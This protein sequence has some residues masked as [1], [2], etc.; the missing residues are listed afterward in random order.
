[1]FEAVEKNTPSISL[2]FQQSLELIGSAPQ[3]QSP[4]W[5]KMSF[6]GVIEHLEDSLLVPFDASITPFIPANQDVM[7]QFIHGPKLF[8]EN[9][10]HPLL[11]EEP[12]PLRYNS[13]DEAVEALKTAMQQYLTLRSTQPSLKPVHP[14][15]GS[16]EF[17]TW[18][19]LMIKH[20]SHHLQQFCLLPR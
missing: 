14:G 11:P 17:P 15:F 4:L 13:L 10:K 19:A 20:F 9:T 12:P 16:L 1:M 7:I 6:Q 18:D 8:R 5:G 3:N 2:F